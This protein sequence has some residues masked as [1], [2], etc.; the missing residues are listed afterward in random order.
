MSTRGIRKISISNPTLEGA[1]VHLR[2]VFGFGDTKET[3]PFLLMDDFRSDYPDH[4]K[5]GFPWHPHRGI[6]TITYV[7]KGTVDHGDSLGNSGTIGPGDVQWMTAGSGIVH[8]EMPHGDSE[9]RMYGFQLWLN[10]PAKLKMTNPR[11][12]D[13][14]KEQIPVVQLEGGVEV[15]VICGKFGDVTGPVQ[16]TAVDACYFDVALSPNSQWTFET[17]TSD[18]AMVYVIDGTGAFGPL[19]KDWAGNGQW[20]EYDHG[21]RVEVSTGKLGTRFLY[22]SASP[23][24]EPVA[25][26]GPI[27]MNT[28]D[29][30]RTAFREYQEGTFVKHGALENTT[31]RV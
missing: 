21:N 9:G 24:K 27:V 19:E 6:E 16:G 17:Q 15:R 12:Q 31:G 8:Q 13:I 14:R 22:L 28:D 11:Y 5:K 26:H 1:G 23:L 7:L 25:W 4:Y 20:V 29:E 3:D 10:L 30:L 18:T 2:R